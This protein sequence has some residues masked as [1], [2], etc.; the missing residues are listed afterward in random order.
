MEYPD[1]IK[2][3]IKSVAAIN[4]SSVRKAISDPYV[5]S[6]I[7]AW[8]KEQDANE[9]ALS[10]NNK[11]GSRAASDDSDIPPDVDLTTEEGRKEYDKWKSDMIKK[12]H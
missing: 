2:A 3:A 5:K 7:D 4:K 11:K 12:G 1:D 6:K 10:R 8:Q 9:A